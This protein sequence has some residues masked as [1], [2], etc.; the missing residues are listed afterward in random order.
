MFLPTVVDDLFPTSD[1]PLVRYSSSYFATKKS[2]ADVRV[3]Y[4][5]SENGA[6]GRSD[7]DPLAGVY[8]T[9]GQSFS[10][11]YADAIVGRDMALAVGS[12]GVTVIAMM[13]H[14]KSPFL[15]MMGLFQIILR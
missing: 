4:D 5:A 8:D 11:Y 10:D 9:T 15:T 7:S 1:P 6:F 2:N 3:M 12:A 13:I 14:T